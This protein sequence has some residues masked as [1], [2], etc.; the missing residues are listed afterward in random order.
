MTK[1]PKI[2]KPWSFLC[3]ALALAACTSAPPAELEPR[4]A[5]TPGRAFA[6]AK[7]G[8][9]HEVGR[10]GHSRNSNAPP[11]HVIANQE[12]LTKDTLTYWL[13]GAHNYPGEMD[14]T[15]REPEV[16]MLVGYMLTLRDPNYKRP[17]D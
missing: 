6:E 14:F 1:D 8:G 13:G 17:T 4:A 5:D 16:D 2:V 9:C 11:F 12:G 7:C 15:L 3:L 10:Y